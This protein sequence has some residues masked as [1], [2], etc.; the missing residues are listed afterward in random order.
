MHMSSSPSSPE[1]RHR[2]FEALYERHS[3]E[4]WAVAYAR[5]M[6]TDTASDIAQ[7]AFF[8]LW[9][10]WET[11]ECIVNPRAW[12]MRVARNLAEDHGKS[13]FRR[14][15]TQPPQMMNGVRSKELLPLECLERQ[16]TFGQ[17]RCLLRELSEADREVLTMRYAFDYSA[18][19][20]ADALGINTTAVH[21]R[22]S[23]A[24]QRLAERLT[25][26]GVTNEV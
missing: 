21:M 19:A 24:R 22:L 7:E 17:L 20:I 2:D 18:Q 4:V 12:L 1:K 23:R 13:A 11:G 14:N 8:R 16:E 5:W 10:Q 3:R 9:K 26:Q 25:A 6:N 15:G